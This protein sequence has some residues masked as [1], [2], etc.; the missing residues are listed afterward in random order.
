MVFENVS[1]NPREIMR[2]H[3]KIYESAEGFICISI[4]FHTFR[5]F[6]E[7]NCLLRMAV[8]ANKVF[9]N[10]WLNVDMTAK[11][12]LGRTSYSTIDL[13]LEN[14]YMSFFSQY[15]SPNDFFI[16]FYDVSGFFSWHAQDLL[17][18]VYH[19]TRFPRAK[20]FTMWVNRA[21]L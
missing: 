11:S 14:C 18:Q 16:A 4:N 3:G 9:L 8:L 13:C 10:M 7:D 2:T 15:L 17:N 5:N 12:R 19:F 6:T 21:F 20:I 1:R